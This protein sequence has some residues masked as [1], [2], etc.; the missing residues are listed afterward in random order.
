MQIIPATLVGWIAKLSLGTANKRRVE[1]GGV[2]VNVVAVWVGL[3]VRLAVSVGTWDADD[4][5]A[6]R[7]D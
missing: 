4:T 3:R 5:A 7:T 6:S 1:A 2:V